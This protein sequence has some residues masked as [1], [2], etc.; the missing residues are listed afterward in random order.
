MKGSQEEGP[1]RYMID[2]FELG[3]NGGNKRRR[4]KRDR[5]RDKREM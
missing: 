4:N 2:R 5:R 3:E 1:N